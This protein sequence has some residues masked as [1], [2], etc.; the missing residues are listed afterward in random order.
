MYQKIRS[1]GP[2]QDRFS[3]G[4]SYIFEAAVGG[5]EALSYRTHSRSGLSSY[6]FEIQVYRSVALLDEIITI[7]LS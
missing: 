4:R 3:F 6:I 5:F 2:N 1:G 7:G